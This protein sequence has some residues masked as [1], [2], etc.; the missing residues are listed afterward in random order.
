VTGSQLRPGAH[1]RECGSAPKR[2]WR[3][4]RARALSTPR[5]P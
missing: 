2:K 1:L 4:R 3:D 5:V